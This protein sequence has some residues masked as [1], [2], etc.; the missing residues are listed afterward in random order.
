MEFTE[1]IKNRYSCRRFKSAPV[2]KEK[3]DVILKAGHIAPTGHNDQPQR[4]LVVTGEEGREK[5]K[6]CTKCHYDAPAFLITCYEKIGSP[7]QH[8]DSAIV[9]THMMLESY[10]QGL[11]S[12]WIKLIDMEKLREVFDIPFNFEILGVLILGYPAD[13]AKPSKLH[14]E[15]Y[16]MEHSVFYET[17]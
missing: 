15:R 4:I 16:P 3:L 7:T 13:N 9:M 11:G 12:T 2:E 10:N 17:F 6:G 14:F 5:M 1:L 8:E